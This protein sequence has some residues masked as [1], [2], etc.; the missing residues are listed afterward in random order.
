M[1]SFTG[2]NL[3]LALSAID[4]NLLFTLH[5][6]LVE[7]SVARAA[8]RLGVTAPAVSNSL[9]RLRE[10]LG[11]PLLVRHGRGLVPTPRAEEIA[12]FLAR[13]TAELERAL[14]GDRTFDPATTTRTF[15]IVC[16]DA[17]QISRIPRIAAALA[18]R[19]PR[20]HLRVRSVD[21]FEAGGG[22]AGGDTDL[23]FI[24]AHPLP[25]GLHTAPLGRDE[26]VM[27]ARR[28]HPGIR[29]RLTRKALHALRYIDIHL[30]LGRGGIGHGAVDA[31]FAA[32]GLRRDIAVTV[33]SFAAAAMVAAETDLVAGMPAHLAQRLVKVLPLRILAL[34]FPPLVFDMQML[35]HERT[36]SDPGCKAFRELVTTAVRPTARRAS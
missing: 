15:S 8:A 5:V 12:P 9:A 30:V 31:F 35:W 11:D 13:A 36:H 27:V 10:L 29:G 24:P 25:P 4:L 28:G 33:P 20:A 17:D 34:P 19:M 18:R 32:H 22:F 16:A 26:G 21:D 14:L 2:M 6:V 1:L 23:V 3:H 7:R